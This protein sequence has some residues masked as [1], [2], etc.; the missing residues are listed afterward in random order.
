MAALGAA[1]MT[2]VAVTWWLLTGSVRNFSRPSS[3]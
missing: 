3:A 2:V 1:A